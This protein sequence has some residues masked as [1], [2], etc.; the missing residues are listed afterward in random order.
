[1]PRP[2]ID[3]N[4]LPPLYVPWPFI[5]NNLLFADVSEIG[6]VSPGHALHAQQL[7][8]VAARLLQIAQPLLNQL[9][10]PPNRTG[11]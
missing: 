6:P 7:G 9:F 10:L 2:L 11:L 4:L 3:N 1:M 8:A 5:D